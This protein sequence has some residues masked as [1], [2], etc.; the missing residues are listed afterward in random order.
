MIKP[1]Y[2]QTDTLQRHTWDAQNQGRR[3]LWTLS[4]ASPHGEAETQ[5]ALE[6]TQPE[7]AMKG[8][9]ALRPTGH[10]EG[11]AGFLEAGRVLIARLL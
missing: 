6:L 5:G 4:R 10:Q 11:R 3:A 2:V 9:R 7:T 8:R 1:D